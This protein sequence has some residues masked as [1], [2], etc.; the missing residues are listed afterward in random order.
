MPPPSEPTGDVYRLYLEHGMQAQEIRILQESLLRLTERFADLTSRV[1]NLEPT[2]TAS[3]LAYMGDGKVVDINALGETYMN[4]PFLRLIFSPAGETQYNHKDP[5]RPS[6]FARGAFPDEADADT[7]LYVC[8]DDCGEYSVSVYRN[9]L[10]PAALRR[11]EHGDGVSLY[12]TRCGRQKTTQEIQA[13]ALQLPSCPSV[14]LE[15]C[16]YKSFGYTSFLLM[17]ALLAH[18]RKVFLLHPDEPQD[19]NRFAKD[20]DEINFI[21]PRTKLT[22]RVRQLEIERVITAVEEAY[23]NH[24]KHSV[25]RVVRGVQKFSNE[26]VMAHIGYLQ[27][28]DELTDAGFCA[29]WF[30]AA[31]K[32][33]TRSDVVLVFLAIMAVILTERGVNVASPPEMAEHLRV[34]WEMKNAPPTQSISGRN[35]ELKIAFDDAVGCSPILRQLLSA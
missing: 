23:S 3:A 9:L 19:A 27:R 34:L 25:A 28:H 7:L 4:S 16:A 35:V 29:A 5:D 17:G 32:L 26:V 21:G 24:F 1:V 14:L 31:Q 22:E 13:D 6:G 33:D 8:G 15:F 18:G 30:S 20:M 11:A 12:M 2:S 10:Y